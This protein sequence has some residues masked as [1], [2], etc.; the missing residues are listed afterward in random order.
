MVT[1]ASGMF[2][3][4]LLK[5]W[6][7]AKKAEG[8]SLSGR[9]DTRACDLTS[10]AAVADLFK[11]NSRKLVIHAAAYSDVD[12]CE[13]DPAR[14]HA[15]N[16]LATQNLAQV[17]GSKNIP[18]VF[19]STDYVFDGRKSSAYA[20]A[21][22][23]F[24]INIYG[25]TKLEGEVHALRC[26]APSVVVRTSWLFGAENPNNFVN[27]ILARLRREAVVAVLDDQEDAPTFVE[28][29]AAAVEV[30]AD[31]LLKKPL[32]GIFHVCNSG[33]ATRHGMALKMKEWIGRGPARV[34]KA[35]PGQ[36]KGRLAVRPGHSVLSTK[37]FESSF[38]MKLRPWEEALEEYVRSCAS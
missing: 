26:A 17:C 3:R 16:A 5:R 19:I 23:T 34:E 1:G 31:S 12:G 29:L 7:S 38:G 2:G 24:P 36:V 35:D 30:I 25:M 27:A 9:H 32:R 10:R 14:A 11:K 15:A 4:A 6:A 18:L 33:S 20:E 8:V 13:R 37:H 28:D 21:D 22:R